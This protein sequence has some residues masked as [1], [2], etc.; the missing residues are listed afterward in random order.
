MR[1]ERRLKFWAGIQLTLRNNKLWL[2]SKLKCCLSGDISFVH[3]NLHT[4]KTILKSYTFHL[5]WFSLSIYICIY[6]CMYVFCAPIILP[7]S[8]KFGR[9]LLWNQDGTLYNILS[10]TL[11]MSMKSAK[12]FCLQWRLADIWRYESS[13]YDD[14]LTSTYSGIETDYFNWHIWTRQDFYKRSH[15]DLFILQ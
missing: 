2:S 6:V 7:Y 4:W 3:Y 9:G 12:T 5:K 10:R 11:P 15:R 14:I 13:I 8:P 1:N